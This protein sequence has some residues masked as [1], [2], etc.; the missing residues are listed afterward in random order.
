MGS[1]REFFWKQLNHAVFRPWKGLLASD[2]SAPQ[3]YYDRGKRLVPIEALWMWTSFW[4]KILDSHPW[5]IKLSIHTW[6]RT[7]RRGGIVEFGKHCNLARKL[8]PDLIKSAMGFK[9]FSALWAVRRATAMETDIA[10][11]DIVWKKGNL[12]SLTL[13]TEF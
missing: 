11:L 7:T 1:G 6:K 5:S 13:C 4:W 12:E 3:I 9:A 2:Q 10:C 8:V